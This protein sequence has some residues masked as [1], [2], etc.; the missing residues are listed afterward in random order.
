MFPSLA[1]IGPNDR[2]DFHIN[3]GEIFL[4]PG[5]VPHSPRRGEG[6]W[7]LVVERQPHPGEVNYYLYYCDQCSAKLRE[8]PRAYGEP[9]P[10]PEE[11][12]AEF[13]TDPALRT[14]K[15]CGF[16]NEG[17]RRA[18][19]PPGKL[20]APSHGASQRRSCL[21]SESSGRTGTT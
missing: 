14:C 11:L 4:M 6:C 1:T 18:P 10:R 5:G 15:T 20:L 9:M 2:R 7:T 12:A 8:W 21:S 16:I 19:E 13:K 3:P 17:V